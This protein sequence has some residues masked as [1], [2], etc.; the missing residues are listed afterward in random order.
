M[1]KFILFIFL[2]S[3]IKEAHLKLTE[4]KRQELLSK[5]TTKISFDNINELKTLDIFPYQ[6]PLTDGISYDPAQIQQLLDENGFPLNYNF[7][8]ETNATVTIKDQAGCGCCWSH[9]ATTALAYRYHL[10]GVEV[11]LSPQDGLSCYLRDCDTGNYL[12][13]PELNLI[14]NGT[15]TE[16]CLP[17]SSMDGKTIEPCP[18]SCKD[19]SEYKKYYAQN[20]YSTQDYYSEDTF[21]EIVTLIIDEL[22]KNGPVVTS[23]M[24]YRDFFDLCN[25]PKKCHDTVYTYDG[26]SKKEGG[27]AVVIVGYGYLNGKFYWLIQNSWGENACD[28]GFVKI[29]FG[30]I[31]V[32]TVAFAEP[33]IPNKQETPEEIPVSLK[34]MDEFCD[35]DVSSTLSKD[36]WKNTLD[37]RFKNSNIEK[38][39]DYQCGKKDIINKGKIIQCYYEI[40]NYYS[41]KGIYEFYNSQSLGTENTFNLDDSFK[42]TK[43]QFWGLDTLEYEYI[44]FFFISEEGSRMTFYY[45]SNDES[46]LPP[47]YP[48]KASSTPLSDCHK[49]D[50]IPYI[51]CEIKKNELSSF[52]YY[53]YP[54]ENPMAYNVL[55]GYKYA[56]IYGFLLNKNDGISLR[57]KNFT[58]PE[59]D[60]IINAN[61]LLTIVAEYDGNINDFTNE[62]HKFISFVKVEYNNKNK[63][64]EMLCNI[65]KNYIQGR[66]LYLKCLFNI[67]ESVTIKYDNIYLLPYYVPY[68]MAYQYEVIIKETIKCAKES[69]NPDPKPVDGFSRYLKSYICFIVGLLILF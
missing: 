8:E 46:I 17:F 67:D 5:L 61:T 13:D 27:H 26:K 44:S 6:S 58:I 48:N 45:E 1:K 60:N 55:C 29:E 15:L 2:L 52:N 66:N 41:N 22:I 51:Y 30:Q 14:K 38:N 19:G 62:N 31:N 23:I 10:I 37:I 34:K 39:F 68:K 40:H 3:I 59:E 42:N 35:I 25:N 33:Y 36:K 65:H 18:T 32:E 9:A 20:A 21:Y 56:F 63:T 16:G 53:S 4:L 28:K 11:D 49:I 57:I 43:F 54:P 47:I 24:V 50:D 7:I 12:I 69:K 64:N